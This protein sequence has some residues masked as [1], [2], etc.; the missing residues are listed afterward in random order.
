MPSPQLLAMAWAVLFVWPTA[1]RVAALGVF[2][3]LAG[4]AAGLIVIGPRLEPRQEAGERTRGPTPIRTATKSPTTSLLTP[5]TP[6][7]SRPPRTP[8]PP[9]PSPTSSSVEPGQASRTTS[10]PLLGPTT[11]KPSVSTESSASPSSASTSVSS[12]VAFAETSREVLETATM[13]TDRSLSA[14][15]PTIAPSSKATASPHDDGSSGVGSN[16]TL[17]VALST[18]LSVVG[19]VLIAAAVLICCR[20]RQRRPHLFSRNISPID[21]D[22]IATWKV[23]RSEKVGFPI[24]DAH[25]ED[26]TSRAEAPATTAAGAF[27]TGALSK[28]TGSPSSHAKHGSTSSAKKPPSVIVYSNAHG[29]GYRVS[30]DEGS[31]RSFAHNARTSYSANKLSLDKALPQ[32]PIQARAPNARAGLTD[33]AIPGDEPF[34]PSPKRQPSRLSKMPPNFSSSHRRFH[35]H[36]RTRSSRSS[37]RSFAG[38]GSAA[39]SDMELSPRH[40]HE[41]RHSHD[42]FHTHH[43]NHSHSRVY[44]SS[45]IPPR[46]SLGDEGVFGGGPSSPP[47]RPWFR[48]D[49]NIGRAIG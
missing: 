21:D 13:P 42:A 48:D 24:G 19:V 46:L 28:E 36:T 14:D 23:P 49:N 1:A 12:G 32:T 38:Y 10:S 20:Y 4:D 37:M 40:S 25:V 11:A 17:V 9:P 22:E 29:Q 30:S 34:L 6:V 18:V 43:G 44:S 41:P 27:V 39:G 15:F 7:V 26:A 31:P 2:D 33:E 8:T 35:H 5:P 3:P 16:R 45:S 47:A